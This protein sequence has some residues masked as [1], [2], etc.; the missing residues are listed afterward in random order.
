MHL[1]CSQHYKVAKP[2]ESSLP[3]EIM[4]KLL[5]MLFLHDIQM[6]YKCTS[7]GLGFLE[8]ENGGGHLAVSLNLTYWANIQHQNLLTLCW[9]IQHQNAQILSPEFWTAGSWWVSASAGEKRKAEDSTAGKAG[10]QSGLPGN[11]S[12]RLRAGCC[13]CTA[14][15]IS[16]SHRCRT[17]GPGRSA[18]HPRRCHEGPLHPRRCRF[19]GLAGHHQRSTPP[20]CWWR[21]TENRGGKLVTSQGWAQSRDTLERQGEKQELVS[22]ELQRQQTTPSTL[23]S[24]CAARTQHHS[25]NHM[26]GIFCRLE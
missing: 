14:L 23:S 13:P 22:M 21:E 25:L 2:L 9:I 7:K 3:K 16:A 26:P 20:G 18:P 4:H 12:N 11:K 19:P 24:G 1:T 17:P 15:W 8:D 6:I 5:D 10:G